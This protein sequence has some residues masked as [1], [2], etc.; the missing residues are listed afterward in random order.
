MTSFW[1][2][3]VEIKNFI[4]QI[5]FKICVW[6]LTDINKAICFLNMCSLYQTPIHS[7]KT[8]FKFP[9]KGT[10]YFPQL[11]A[12]ISL[13]NSKVYTYFSKCSHSKIF[14]VSYVFSTLLKNISSCKFFQKWKS[15]PKIKKEQNESCFTQKGYKFILSF[16][17]DMKLTYK[18]NL[19]FY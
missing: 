9:M 10:N 13:W 7:E 12:F 15:Y 17:N 11:V 8:V 5:Y 16:K 19:I 4:S 18:F 1:K 2:T 14:S 3:Q 6:I